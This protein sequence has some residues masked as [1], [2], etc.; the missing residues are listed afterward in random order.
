[1]L[2]PLL[3]QSNKN[4]ASPITGINKIVGKQRYYRGINCFCH[5]ITGCSKGY[6][7]RRGGIKEISSGH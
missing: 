7:A 2:K 1:M 4:F 5:K 6:M 3:K